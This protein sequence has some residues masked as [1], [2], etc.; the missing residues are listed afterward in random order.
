MSP[1]PCCC[2]TA[3]RTS[4]FPFGNGQWLAAHIPWAKARLLDNDGHVTLV[5]RVGDVH[6]WLSERL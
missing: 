5:D 1:F 3:G 2:C 6:A 4:S